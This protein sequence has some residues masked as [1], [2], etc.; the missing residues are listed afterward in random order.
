LTKT[1]PKVVIVNPEP[2]DIVYLI[3]FTLGIPKSNIT[4]YQEYFDENFDIAK[5]NV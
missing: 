3:E 1:L 5:L 2:T 4:I